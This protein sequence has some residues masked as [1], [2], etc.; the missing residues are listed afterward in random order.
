MALEDA[1][2]NIVGEKSV[3]LAINTGIITREGIKSIQGIPF[4]M[5]LI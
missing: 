1:T 3:A 4:A 5:V 2:F